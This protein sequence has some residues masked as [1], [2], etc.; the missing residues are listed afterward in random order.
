MG[1]ED[2]PFARIATIGSDG[3]LGAFA[4]S[5]AIFVA[6]LAFAVIVVLAVGTLFYAKGAVFGV[7]AGMAGI[8]SW[9][10]A[11]QFALGVALLAF[12]FRGLKKAKI[13]VT[14]GHALVIYG[15]SCK[16]KKRMRIYFT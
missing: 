11:S 2:G 16:K 10:V 3:V 14:R 15:V 4:A 7:F 1:V 13:G 6:R 9:A 8:G 5:D 12:L